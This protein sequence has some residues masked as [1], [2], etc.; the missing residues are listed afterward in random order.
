[1]GMGMTAICGLSFFFT[2]GILMLVLACSLPEYDN[3][4]PMLVLITYFLTPLPTLIAKRSASSSYSLDSTSSWVGDVALFFT[5]AFVVSGF[6][7]P[8]VLL[9][10]DQIEYGAAGLIC[11]GNAVMFATIGAFFYLSNDDVGL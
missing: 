2:M 11:G 7:I 3:Y 8:L 1:M 10:A 4:Y 9:R 6:G 5:A